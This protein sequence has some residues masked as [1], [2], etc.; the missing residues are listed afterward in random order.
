MHNKRF[1]VILLII[2]SLS[3]F[4]SC[5]KD[6]YSV[7]IELLD[8]QFQDLKSETF[9]I[10]SYQESLE[11]VQ[12]NNLSNVHLGVFNDDFFGQTN[13]GFISQLNVALLETFGE[14]NQNEETEGSL[15]DI[16]VINEQEELTAVYLDLPFYNNTNDSDGDGVIDAYDADPNNVE[17]DSDNDGLSDIIEFQAGINPLSNDSDND[18]ILDPDD[19]DNSSY[20][21][22]QRVYEIDSVFGNRNAEFDLKVYELTYYLSSLDPANN[23]ESL[24]EY[25]S[26]DDFYK[27]GYYGKTLHDDRVSLDFNEVPVLYNEDDP[28][29]DP[30]ELTQ[31]NYFE[32]PRIR[33]PLDT[34]FFQRSVMNL[35]GSEKIVN[36][37]NFNNFFKGIIVR[38]E[39]F[40]DDLYMML[41][42]FNARIVLEYNY[43]SYN[44]NG[45]D[46]IS[47]D[48]IDR[49]KTS[50]IIPLGGVTI[51][52]YDQVNFDQ[53]ILTE[54]NSSAENIPSE[55]IYLNGSKFI[56]KL[57]L[58]SDDNSIS[59]ELSS[60]MSKN[61]LINEANIVLHLDDNIN[62][63]SHK[64]LPERLYIYSYDNGD[65]IEDYNKDFSI[66]FSPTAI[67]SNKFRFGGMLQ[68]DSNNKPT[69]YKFNI[70]NH[71][72]NIVRYD[73]LN[74]DLGLTTMSNI[75]DVFTLKNG[76]LPNMK[77]V[78]LPSS[79]LSLPFPVALF[80]SS[81]D[82]ANLSKRIKLEVLYTEY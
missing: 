41:D 53:K 20:N 51:N 71:V 3:L 73:S 21:V 7:G 54:V 47:D 59:D 56:S 55:K 80:G 63:S 9:P 79:S 25:F 33:I 81:P 14:W 67:N 12:T 68:Y 82:Q 57:K 23:F 40:S 34:E 77:K 19:T 37:A 74:I 22:E 48:S 17:S 35:E 66:D 4:T 5:N 49:K 13:S 76:Y 50:S 24:K 28:T 11:R 58:F 30:D 70:T 46:D 36:Q 43:N 1:S 75:D 27:K 29:T 8:Q 18:G 2:F 32:T 72:S 61:V 6:Y 31:V 38:A 26:D 78:S 16:R 62:N 10:F 52:L 44:T 64:F 42:I 69:S 39:N 45:T 15:T 65:P 60:F